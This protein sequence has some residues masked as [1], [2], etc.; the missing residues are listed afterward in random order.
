MGNIKLVCFDL[1]KTLIH[2]NSW[3]DL[4]RALGVTDE[5]DELFLRLY[6]EGIITYI[7]WTDLLTRIYKQRGKANRQNAVN[8]LHNYTYVDGA[9]EIVTYLQNKGY[10]IALISGSIDILVGRVAAELGITLFEANHRFVFDANDQLKEIVTYGQDDL[11]K[12]NHLEHFCQTIGIRLTEC[13]CVGDGDNDL[14]LFRRT[15]HGITF[16][17]SKIAEEAEYTINSLSDLRNIL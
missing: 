1:N 16:T 2:E 15:G 10:Q 4:N 17:G 7:E 14:E 13:V 12:V 6:D 3:L 5:E 11:A 9:K 8:A